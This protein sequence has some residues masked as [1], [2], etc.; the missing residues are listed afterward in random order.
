MKRLCWHDW[1]KW[2]SQVHCYDGIYQYR[3]CKKCNFVIKK[4]RGLSIFHNLEVWN[5]PKSDADL[6][7]EVSPDK[8]KGVEGE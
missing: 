5:N 8:A 1:T 7:L 6:I 2:S 4:T 3:Y